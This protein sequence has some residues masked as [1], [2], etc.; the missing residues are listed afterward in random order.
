MARWK[1]LSCSDRYGR[2]EFSHELIKGYAP[3]SFVSVDPCTWIRSVLTC[4]AR[5][6]KVHLRCFYG[7]STFTN[8]RRLALFRWIKADPAILGLSFGGN[9]KVIK[10][11]A[12]VASN[13]LIVIM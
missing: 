10:E 1:C 3:K 12:D 5:W 2:N 13:L 6:I 7:L 9:D 8:I 11:F 4:K